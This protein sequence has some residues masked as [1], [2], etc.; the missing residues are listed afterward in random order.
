MGKL[1]KIYSVRFCCVIVFFSWLG[2]CKKDA[3]IPKPE[4]IYDGYTSTLNLGDTV[5]LGST[6]NMNVQKYYDTIYPPWQSDKI[7]EFDIDND[8][9]SD[10]TVHVA[11]YNSLGGGPGFFS[12][13]T[14]LGNFSFHGYIKT[15]TLFMHP[16]STIITDTVPPIFVNITIHR[17][18]SFHTLPTPFSING[19]YPGIFKLSPQSWNDVLHKSMIFQ[20][21]LTELNRT[22]N[23][24]TMAIM[25]ISNDTMQFLYYHNYNDEYTFPMDKD[26]FIG[27][28]KDNGLGVAK[29]GWIKIRCLSTNQIAILE[30]AIQK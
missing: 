5:I 1:F 18:I 25:S 30:T 24:N 16:D 7:K 26:Y 2:S 14:G 9:A 28:K 19:L 23:G 20:S 27:I 6:V 12:T 4:V 17:T 22:P 29:L 21:G 11:A 10:F 8:A 3:P 13:I 15:D